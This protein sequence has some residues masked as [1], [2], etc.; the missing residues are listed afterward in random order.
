MQAQQKMDAS[1]DRVIPGDKLEL[2][3][4]EAVEAEVEARAAPDPTPEPATLLERLEHLFVRIGRTRTMG[5][6]AQ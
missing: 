1:D 3:R 6:Q 2:T 5:A 4:E